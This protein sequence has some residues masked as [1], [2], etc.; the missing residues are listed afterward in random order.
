MTTM[1]KT[2]ISPVADIIRIEKALLAP[3]SS[4]T[5]ND[6]V[7]INNENDVLSRSFDFDDDEED[8]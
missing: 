8:W 1:K 3:A 6:D 4:F 5:K 7:E 2:Y